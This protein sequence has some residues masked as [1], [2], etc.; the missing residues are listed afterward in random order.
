M[1]AYLK[2]TLECKQWKNI[3]DIDDYQI[4]CRDKKFYGTQHYIEE[5]FNE[6][7]DNDYIYCFN[8]ELFGKRKDN[9][10]FSHCDNDFFTEIDDCLDGIFI[11]AIKQL[12]G[13]DFL[14][15][16]LKLDFVSTYS[17]Y[18]DVQEGQGYFEVIEF[19]QLT[20]AGRSSD[21]V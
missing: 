1:D 11:Q 18:P 13:K 8:T 6:F 19:K 7:K 17:G 16:T 12:R 21:R 4:L 5:E 14:E 9:P 15:F 10:Y 2:F 20:R 3:S